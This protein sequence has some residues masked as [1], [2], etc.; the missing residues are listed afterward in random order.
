MRRIVL[1]ALLACGITMLAFS[2]NSVLHKHNF[3]PEL[4]NTKKL[5][6]NG[7]WKLT[8]YCPNSCCNMA[9]TKE[10]VVD[11]TN[12]AAVSGV[13]LTGLLDNG[14]NI[15]AVDTDIIPLGSIIK[16]SNKYYIALDTGSAVKGFTLD[17]LM[18]EHKQTEEFGVQYS[19]DIEVYVPSNPKK[20]IRQ[21]QQVSGFRK[22]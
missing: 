12:C 4:S 11:Y 17:I 3:L 8:A 13:T 7:T 19:Q 22:P 6:Y 18:R 1:I 10:G 15:V 14:I 16:Y 20:I 21:M 9:Y 5:P 2:Y